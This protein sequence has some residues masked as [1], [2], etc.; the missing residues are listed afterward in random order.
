MSKCKKC[1]KKAGH[2]TQGRCWQCDQEARERQDRRGN[3]QWK[4]TKEGVK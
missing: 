4:N 3:N 1:G 2:L